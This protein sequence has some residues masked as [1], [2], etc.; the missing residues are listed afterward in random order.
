MQVISYAIISNRTK[1]G[2]N[3]KRNDHGLAVVRA[4][5][6]AFHTIFSAP[7]TWREITLTLRQAGPVLGILHTFMYLILT[8]SL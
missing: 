6:T 3:R 7:K 1:C 8:I 2:R 5:P 4:L